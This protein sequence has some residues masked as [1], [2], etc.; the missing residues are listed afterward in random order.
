MEVHSK[1]LGVYCVLY[2]IKDYG[3]V[4]FGDSKKT[5]VQTI[6]YSRVTTNPNVRKLITTLTCRKIYKLLVNLE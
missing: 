4:V 6:L 1:L 2:H 5:Y 3:V